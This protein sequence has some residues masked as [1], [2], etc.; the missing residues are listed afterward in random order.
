MTVR[1]RFDG[2]D[3]KGYSHFYTYL[4]PLNSEPADRTCVEPI[5]DGG[6]VWAIAVGRIVR[7]RWMNDVFAKYGKVKI[8]CVNF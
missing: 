8:E 2:K 6:T 7:S 3:Q 4:L 1:I 5:D